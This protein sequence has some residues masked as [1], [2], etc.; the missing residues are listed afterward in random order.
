MPLPKKL[1]SIIWLV[2][3]FFVALVVVS[4]LVVVLQIDALVKV[5]FEKVTPR[6]LGVETG[7]QDV[8]VSFLGGSIDLTGLRIGNPEGFES[9][10]LMKAETIRVAADI[11]ALRKNEIHIQ[12]VILA[13]PEFTFEHNGRTSN[14]QALLDN[15][16][17]GKTPDEE[18]EP[19]EPEKK[20]PGKRIKIDLVRITNAKVHVR[21]LG[22]GGEVG[23]SK[24]EIKNIADAEGNGVPPDELA[25]TITVAMLKQIEVVAQAS[26]LGEDLKKLQEE[27][28]QGARELKEKIREETGMDVDVEGTGKKILDTTKGLFNRKRE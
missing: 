9:P 14:I 21:L 20:G 17:K 28:A 13:G 19:D 1:K 18:E 6:I 3:G 12:E 15:I 23:M 16:E 22:H 2:A 26:Q 27:A 5:A 8:D 25:K 10:D 24:F 4:V 7:L 11:S